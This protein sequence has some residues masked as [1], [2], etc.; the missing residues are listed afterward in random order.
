M[1]EERETY[2]G[3]LEIYQDQILTLTKKLR[4]FEVAEAKRLNTE[5]TRSS[6]GGNDNSFSGIKSIEKDE[7]TEAD[8]SKLLKISCELETLRIISEQRK[9]ELLKSEH[10]RSELRNENSRLQE[11]LARIPDDLLNDP[12]TS[13]DMLDEIKRLREEL[14]RQK[15]RFENFEDHVNDQMASKDKF[16]AEL[17]SSLLSRRF[18]ILKFIDSL[19]QEVLDLRRERDNM[20]ELYEHANSQVSSA[21][22]SIASLQG[23][24]SKMEKREFITENQ[25]SQLL[26][27]KG[28]LEKMLEHPKTYDE[29]TE[30]SK[31]LDLLKEN[32]VNLYNE[33]E[34]LGK[35]F[36]DIQFQNKNLIK[37]IAEKDELNGQ[38][39][40]EKL[41]ARNSDLY[42]LGKKQ[43]TAHEK[44]IQIEKFSLERIEMAESIEKDARK[45][46]SD[47]KNIST[48]LIIEN[49]KLQNTFSTL[50]VENVE[51][52][53]FRGIRH[54]R[55]KIFL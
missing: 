18:S 27:I 9:L 39:L 6:A 47:G 20:R 14:S 37:Q 43:K 10:D 49:E 3:R 45:L 46:I 35:A 17:E 26:Q 32:E 55:I 38:I 1:E 24:I 25:E 16:L 11:K 30:C 22:R 28:L 42:K 15:K 33:L 41:K 29:K 51:L 13:V 54:L 12:R 23:L 4:N 53:K 50:A 8:S 52:K 40:K 7:M 21:N 5:L 34:M 48:N 2:K 44:A 31:I 36:E 19:Q